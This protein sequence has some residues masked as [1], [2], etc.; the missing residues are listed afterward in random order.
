MDLLAENKYN[1]CVSLVMCLCF[2]S[3]VKKLPAMC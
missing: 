1:V 3:V 2:D